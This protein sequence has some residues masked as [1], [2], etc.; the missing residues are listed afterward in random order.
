M[1][2]NEQVQDTPWLVSESDK[3][4]VA[5]I[6]RKHPNI[7]PKVEYTYFPTRNKSRVNRIPKEI[8]ELKKLETLMISR[9]GL[10]QN[11][12]VRKLQKRLPNCG[13]G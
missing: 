10:F 5:E 2:L 6:Y 4:K 9:T 11:R 12:K 1:T 7:K 8:Q 13:V 3:A